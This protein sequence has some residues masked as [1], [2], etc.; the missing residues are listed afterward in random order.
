M[1]AAVHAGIGAALGSL[2][3]DRPSAF[4]AGVAS[5]LITDAL[6]HVDCRPS[7]EVPLLAAALAGIAA[8]KGANS[9]EFWGSVGA[10]APDFEH[11]LLVTGLIKQEHEVFP[12][13]IDGGRY[14]GRETHSRWPQLAVA[15]ASVLIVA[16][17]D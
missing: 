1:I 2:L 15:L 4:A 13:H 3:G 9:P 8:W 12:T 5:H 17:R 10:V 6:P 14:H 7:V 16:L 11:A